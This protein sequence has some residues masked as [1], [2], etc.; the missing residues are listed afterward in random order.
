MVCPSLHPAR[1]ITTNHIMLASPVNLEIINTGIAT[2]NVMI[3][4]RIM[5][6]MM[7][8]IVTTAI[9]TT[10]V[11]AVIVTVQ[12]ATVATAAAVATAPI[13]IVITAAVAATVPTVI[14]VTVVMTVTTAITV[15]SKPSKPEKGYGAGD[16][17]PY[18][19]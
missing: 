4:A 18:F 6:V 13:A 12:I 11:A 8:V 5:T 14:A 3:I 9:V 16:P 17:A 1:L 15:K 2:I 7:V 10:V 19:Q